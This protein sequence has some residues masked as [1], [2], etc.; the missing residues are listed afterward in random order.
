MCG[1]VAYLG[2]REVIEILLR[3]LQR[4]EY[5]YVIY[6]IGA[7]KLPLF[8]CCGTQTHSSIKAS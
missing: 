3:G 6:C 1:I 7:L 4:L 5:R 8:D 2:Y